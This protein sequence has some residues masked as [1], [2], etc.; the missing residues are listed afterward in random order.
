MMR[1][2][3]TY[4]NGQILQHFG[5]TEQF[6]LYDVQDG[7]VIATLDCRCPITADLNHLR[8]TAIAH[9]PGFIIDA[10]ETKEPHHVPAESEL[11]SAL[12]AAYHEETGLEPKAMSTGGGTYAKVLKQGVAYGAAFPDEE[13]LAHQAGEYAKISSLMKSVRVFANAL[14]RLAAE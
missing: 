11:V 8:E 3:V 12:L 9:L 5:H 14:L 10:A 4:K 7:N 6:K 2:A 13:D 1:I